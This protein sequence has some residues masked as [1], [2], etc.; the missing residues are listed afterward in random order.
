MRSTRPLWQLEERVRNHLELVSNTTLAIMRPGCLILTAT[1][2][3]SSIKASRRQKVVH[4]G[5]APRR[6]SV[7][8]RF[9]GTTYSRF[10]G[11]VLHVRLYSP[12]SGPRE[13]HSPRCDAPAFEAS[14][15]LNGA[16]RVVLTSAMTQN[17]L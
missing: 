9:R 7:G 4:Q 5:G 6:L 17:V 16:R 2:L 15:A 1:I 8:C 12:S 10:R 3:R 11:N 14:V 13:S